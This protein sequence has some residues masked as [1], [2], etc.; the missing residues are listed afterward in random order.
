MND[1]GRASTRGRIMNRRQDG[2]GAEATERPA[3][4]SALPSGLTSTA[5]SGRRRTWPAALA[6]AALFA[7]APGAGPAPALAQ[8]NNLCDQPGEAPD[9]IVGD[10]SG[11]LRHGAIGDI[12]AFSIGTTSCN[13][14]TCRANW[15][16]S[17]AEH[18]AIGQNMFRLKNGRFEQIGQS[19]LKHASVAVQ[20][21]T[22]SSACMAADSS[23]LGVNCSD[24]Y[25]ASLNG[26]QSRLGPKFEVN[27]FTGAFPFP[28]TSMSNTG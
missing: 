5:W 6:L 3:G 12:T 18:P 20:G 10:I 2:R 7:A 17:T 23:H 4:S 27:A 24:P 1:A 21:N 16:S 13:L 22:C 8:A 9:V 11:T 15:I 26:G 19:W 14:G 28:A 25:G